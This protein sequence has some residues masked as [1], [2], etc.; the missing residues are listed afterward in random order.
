MSQILDVSRHRCSGGSCLCVGCSKRS[1]N[2][3]E[4]DAQNGIADLAFIN[5]AIPAL[6]SKCIYNF[7]AR[8]ALPSNG[9]VGAPFALTDS[10]E[11]ALMTFIQTVEKSVFTV[12]ESSIRNHANFIIKWRIEGPKTPL[13]ASWVK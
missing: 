8:E 11:Q 12:T 9:K 10:E 7:K 1:Y 6:S 4:S 13:S 3:S 2:S 5:K